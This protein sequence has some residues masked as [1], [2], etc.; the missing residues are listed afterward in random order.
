MAEALAILAQ[1][2]VFPGRLIVVAVEAVVETFLAAQQ[3]MEA[4]VVLGL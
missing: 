2:M 3:E 1:E 4:P